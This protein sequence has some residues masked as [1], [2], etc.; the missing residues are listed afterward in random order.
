[1]SKATICSVKA[2]TDNR[3]DADH[4]TACDPKH[5]VAS[6]AQPGTKQP[7]R[8]HIDPTTCERDYTVQER[9]FMVALDTYKR[10]SGRMFPTCSEILE[11]IRNLGYVQ[12]D[13]PTNSTEIAHGE[14][15][16]RM[17]PAL[18]C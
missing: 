12:C 8:R 3:I 1:M 6:G 10:A 13:L 11:V 7:R 2:E 5:V 9:E 4:R 15:D 18:T 17:S 14:T 16:V